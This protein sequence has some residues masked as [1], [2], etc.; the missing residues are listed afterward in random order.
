MSAYYRKLAKFHGIQKFELYEVLLFQLIY[1]TMR[2]GKYI[3]IIPP[4]DYPGKLYRNRYA[5][6]HHVV[7]WLNTGEIAR[8]GEDIHHID[9]NKHNNEFSNLTKLFHVEHCRL[10]G[11]KRRSVV[12]LNC[13]WCGARFTRRSNLVKFKKKMGQTA[14]FCCKS[15]QVM[16]QYKNK[17]SKT[18][19][20]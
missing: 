8:P 11:E 16:Q 17:L 3:L 18:V 2:N 12:E 20:V 19:P 10:H 15:H 14:F 5:Y 9:D 7:W 6:E 1:T 13:S 4:A